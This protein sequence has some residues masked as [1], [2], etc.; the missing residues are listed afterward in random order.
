MKE[1]F[2]HTTC[3]GSTGVLINAMI[4][5]SKTVTYRTMMKHCEGMLEFAKE[6]GYYRSRSQGLTLKRDWA[7]SYRKSFYDG[8]PCY[9]FRWSAIEHIWTKEI[10]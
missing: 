4:N 9:Y 3:V 5:Q 2:F 7:V 8:L 6:L 10:K 1:Y